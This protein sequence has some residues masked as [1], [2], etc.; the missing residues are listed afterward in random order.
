M[1]KYDIVTSFNPDGLDLYGRNMLNSYVENWSGDNIKLHAW[2]HDFGDTPF[3]LRFNELEIPTERINY[4]NLNNVKDMLDYREKMKIHDGTEEG[5][6]KYNWRLDA[7]KWCHKVYALTETASDPHIIQE[8]DWLIW[9]DADTTTHSEITGEFL[10]SICDEQYDIIH[11]G[12]TAADYS[13][14]SLLRSTSRVDLPKI[15]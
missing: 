11:L 7:I 2:Y 8:K 15:S 12:R 9:L 14:T 10:D 3:Y 5:K 13:E 6:I 1:S 4:C